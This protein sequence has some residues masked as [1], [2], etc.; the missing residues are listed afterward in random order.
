MQGVQDHHTGNKF[1]DIGYHYGIACDGT[2]L[3]GRDIRFQ[4]SSVKL[5]NTGVIG[6]VFVEN[7]TTAE[8][9]G[10]MITKG[11]EA[12][13]HMGYSTTNVIP[14]AQIDA[15]LRLTEASKMGIFI[16]RFGGHKKFPGQG[17]EGKTCP[18]NIGMEFVRSTRSKTQ[19]LPTPRPST[20]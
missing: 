8:E 6:V 4:A 14:T 19:F 11:R 18:E 1:D 12:L 20:E 5:F 2:V 7:L 3:K 10:D 17:R 15:L 9:G 16:E 13:E